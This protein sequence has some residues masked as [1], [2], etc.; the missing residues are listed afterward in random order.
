MI[1]EVE[2][3]MQWLFDDPNRAIPVSILSNV[4]TTLKTDRNSSLS[5]RP[6]LPLVA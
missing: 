5:D 2:N 6:A 1:G 3:M 4:L